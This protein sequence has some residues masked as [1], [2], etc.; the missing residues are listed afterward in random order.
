MVKTSTHLNLQGKVN[1]PTIKLIPGQANLLKDFHSTVLAA[2]AGTGGGK[3]SFGLIWL[4]S[5]MEA[6]P[7]YGWLV[8][9]PTYQML[10]KILL[11]SPDP[12]RLDIIKYFEQ[13][14]HH[15]DY[16]AGEKILKTDFGLVYLASADN[17][18][19]MQGAAVRGSW[20]D[21]G[22]M[23]SLQAHEAAFQRRS[24]MAGQELITTT[25]YNMGWLKTEIADKAGDLIHVEKWASADRPGFPLEEV[26]KARRLLNPSIFKMRYEAAFERPEGLVY[27]DFDRVKHVVSVKKD[28]RRVVAGLDWGFVAPGCILVIAEDNDKRHY[29]IHEEYHTGITVDQWAV[30]AGHLKEEFKIERF[31]CDPSEPNNI[32]M[33]KKVLLPAVAADNA[34]LPGINKVIEGWR[35]GMLFILEGAAPHLIDELESYHWNDKAIKDSPVKEND[36][37]ADT[38]RYGIAG[39]MAGSGFGILIA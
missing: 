15:P 34:V 36:H 12:N 16:S 17:P 8:A 22:G 3:T 26:E 7:G 5:R 9:E 21:E 24:M 27:T 30:I 14:G 6:F 2:I 37:A 32:A 10:A 39:I 4:H 33:F 23:M 11:N 13:A 29:I 19:T 38:L 31:Y 28:W 18:D 20:L 35:A 1:V 25:P